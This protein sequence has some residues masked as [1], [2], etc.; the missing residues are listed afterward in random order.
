MFLV[1]APREYETAVGGRLVSV[2]ETDADAAFER[3]KTLS[4][5]DNASTVLFNAPLLL[6]VAELLLGARLID[7]VMQPNFVLELPD[8]EQMTLNPAPEPWEQASGGG[9]PVGLPQ[10]DEPLYLSRREETFWM[11]GLDGDGALYIQHN[12][13]QETDSTGRSVSAFARE[14]EA[15]RTDHPGARVILDLRHNSGGDVAYARPLLNVFRQDDFFQQAGSLI[16]LIGRNTFSAAVILCVWL[17]QAVNPVFIGEPTGGQPHSFENAL[18][19][20]LPNSQLQ[21]LIARRRRADVEEGDERPAIEPHLAVSLSSA[22]FFE[23]R[24][25]VLDAALAYQA[26]AQPSH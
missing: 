7:D 15:W 24:D 3:L 22:D 9:T 25:P 14:V 17:E 4:S 8:G 21:I 20:T 23:G 26:T 12:A 11:A 2:G 5:Y 16:V 1:D 6:T 18:T 19:V 10:R 13:V